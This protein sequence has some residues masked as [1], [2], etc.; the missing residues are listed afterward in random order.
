M[1]WIVFDARDR[2]RDSK[3]AFP[4]ACGRTQGGQRPA[5]HGR[6]SE[7]GRYVARCLAGIVMLRARGGRQAPRGS[8]RHRPA[9]DGQPAAGKP[10]IVAGGRGTLALFNSS[11]SLRRPAGGAVGVRLTCPWWPSR[12]VTSTQ[13]L[14]IAISGDTEG[15]PVTATEMMQQFTIGGNASGN[16]PHGGG[17]AL[18]RSRCRAGYLRQLHDRATLVE[19]G[20]PVWRRRRLSAPHFHTSAVGARVMWRPRSSKGVA[21]DAGAHTSP[22]VGASVFVRF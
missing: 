12:R 21:F 7:A 6:E 20:L 19:T 8:R 4:I 1:R 16:L 9:V 11:A 22:A 10:R 18:R 17:R 13:P 15:A 14:R 3:V 5:D 2:R